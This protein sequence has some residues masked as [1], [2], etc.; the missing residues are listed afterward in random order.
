MIMRGMLWL[1]LRGK[2][3]VLFG[4][5]PVK[6]ELSAGVLQN[7]HPVTIL[8]AA[9]GTA[10]QLQLQLCR[11]RGTPPLMQIAQPEI[12][13]IRTGDSVLYPRGAIRVTIGDMVMP[14]MFF[15]APPTNVETFERFMEQHPD[16]THREIWDAA[17]AAGGQLVHT[18]LTGE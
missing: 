9:T 18:L 5:A 11:G 13:D 15:P 14:E 2:D 16:A 7:A 12:S 17:Y 1:E 8:A 6:M 4:E 10:L 3:N